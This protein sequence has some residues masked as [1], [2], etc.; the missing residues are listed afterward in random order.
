M[1]RTRRLLMS[2]QAEQIQSEMEGVFQALVNRMQHQMPGVWRPHLEVYET[3]NALVVRAELAG[4]DEETLDVSVEEHLLRVRGVRRRESHEEKRVYHQMDIAFGP[5]AAEVF[6]PFAI[7]PDAVEA[8]YEAGVLQ[9][10]LPKVPP[11]RVVPR[12]VRVTTANTNGQDE[13]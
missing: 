1:D 6:I 8:T 11:R 7:A 3:G 12:S 10:I 2:R 9:I 13:E 4:I 5:F